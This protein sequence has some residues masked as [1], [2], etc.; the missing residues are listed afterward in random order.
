M[1]AAENCDGELVAGLHAIVLDVAKGKRL[2]DGV[3]ICAR[4]NLAKPASSPPATLKPQ[5]VSVIER[6]VVCGSRT[7][8]S[9]DDVLAEF[10]VHQMN[11]N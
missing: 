2:A 1:R 6:K 9:E 3:A 11:G 4:S 5:V 8:E 7:K 10:A